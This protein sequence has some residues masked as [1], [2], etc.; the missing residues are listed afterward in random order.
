M[1]VILYCGFEVNPLVRTLLGNYHAEDLV[2]VSGTVHDFMLSGLRVFYEA[3]SVI[4]M[5]SNIGENIPNEAR[6]ACWKL[7][8]RI[9]VSVYPPVP[10]EMVAFSVFRMGLTSRGADV[11]SSFTSLCDALKL[12]FTVIPITENIPEIH[13]KS[14]GH[15]TRLLGFLLSK[16]ERRVEGVKVNWDFKPLKQPLSHLKSSESVLIV[17]SD[18]VSILPLIRNAEV[19]SALKACEGQVTLV[20][21][22]V[23]P[24]VKHVLSGLGV[25]A[26]PLSLVRLFEKLTD[27]I[28]L[29]QSLSEVRKEV[30]SSMNV[31]VL[32]ADLSPSTLESD[33]PKVV[34]NSFP[35]QKKR[36][37]AVKDMI[38]GITRLIRLEKKE[39][40][41][42]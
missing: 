7:L 23:T 4:F 21:P 29:D 40:R 8:E 5:A 15:E 27:R 34:L 20:L 38:K 25:E 31:E 37:A 39:E 12:G 9:G 30:S 11:A 28:I 22:P 1:F 35:L 17:P 16:E 14:N 33:V 41:E 6:Y 10:E 18:P 13:V 32:L 26:S 3:D 36:T 19:C 24:K 2:V 42:P